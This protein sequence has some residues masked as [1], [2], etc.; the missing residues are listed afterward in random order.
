MKLLLLGKQASIC[1]V[2]RHFH[3]KEFA[4][5]IILTQ[6]IDALHFLAAQFKTVRVQVFAHVFRI[7]R[8]RNDGRILLQGPA[9]HDLCRTLV[10]VASNTCNSV[11]RFGGRLAKQATQTRI[12]R[13]GNAM[14]LAIVKRFD[15]P[16]RCPWIIRHLMLTLHVQMCVRERPRGGEKCINI[17]I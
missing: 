3:E 12:G 15:G 5:Q 16:I 7:A 6:G 17:Y 11:G 2:R 13:D 1:S 9:Q 14:F 10:L 4:R 8:S